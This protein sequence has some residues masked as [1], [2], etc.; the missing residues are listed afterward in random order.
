LL[1][2]SLYL[3]LVPL[4]AQE[5]EPGLANPDT[6]PVNSRQLLALSTADYP[7]TPG[8]VYALSFRP[9]GGNPVGIQLI[10]DTRYQLKVLNLGNV[11]ARGKT[12]IQLCPDTSANETIR[13]YDTFIAARAEDF[14]RDPY[15]RP[16]DK[17]QF[18][19]W[20]LSGNI[21]DE[22]MWLLLLF[23]EY[24]YNKDRDAEQRRLPQRPGGIYDAGQ[25]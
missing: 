4:E 12:Y 14:S 2:F 8:D 24:A 19:A 25:A 16:G 5:R 20:A 17:I 13:L 23:D 18:E 9:M 11:N 10:L 21:F 3:A 22:V 15:I 7:A 6:A 1:S